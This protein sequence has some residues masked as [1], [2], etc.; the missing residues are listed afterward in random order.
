MSIVINLGLL[1]SFLFAPQNTMTPDQRFKSVTGPTL[2]ARLDSACKLALSDG[3]QQRPFWIGYGFN[4]RHG[5]A[6]D[7]MPEPGFEQQHLGLFFHYTADARTVTRFVVYDLDRPHKFDDQV[8][9]LGQA[10]NAESLAYV[11]GILQTKRGADM[12]TQLLETI[13]MH[14]DP[15]AV[16]ILEEIKQHSDAPV[17]RSMAAYWLREVAT[18]KQPDADLP[19]NVPALVKILR[20]PQAD[21]ARRG[22]A[23][24]ALG[25]SADPAGIQEMAKYYPAADSSE[26]KRRILGGTANKV[27]KDAVALYA[28]VA[29]TETDARLKREALNWLGEKAG[30]RLALIHEPDDELSAAEIE[31]EK[32]KLAA[33]SRGAD[34]VAALINVARI[35]QNEEV[36]RA[37]ISYLN[38]TDDARVVAF[39]R[40]VL[41]QP[42]GPN[43][44]ASL[45]R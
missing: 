7:I 16:A 11:R 27:N 44:P 39:Y 42:V 41:A 32:H 12:A 25:L 20:D 26:L 24:Q 6:V 14:D 3:A 8:Y 45:F 29:A 13:S 4:V 35:A 15:R 10:E 23:A 17:E 5:V 38:R 22:R 37:A 43:A 18:S 1:I 9:W 30:N 19:G 2:N 28:M 33:L 40:E 21:P 36:R 31:R 34:A